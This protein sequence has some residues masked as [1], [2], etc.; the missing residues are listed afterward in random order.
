MLFLIIIAGRNPSKFIGVTLICTI[1]W[2]HIVSGYR[3]T[4]IYL[5]IPWQMDSIW[6]TDHLFLRKTVAENSLILLP[7]YI[8]L[9]YHLSPSTSQVSTWAGRYLEFCLLPLKLNPHGP[10]YFILMGSEAFKNGI[11]TFWAVSKR[12]DFLLNGI[13]PTNPVW[14]LINTSDKRRKCCFLREMEWAVYNKHTSCR[15]GALKQGK[16]S[17]TWPGTWPSE[18]KPLCLGVLPRASN[19]QQHQES[20]N[21]VPCFDCWKKFF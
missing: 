3:Y 20:N 19:L 5:A 16:G 21:Q 2:M 4:V 11:Q 15:S 1:Q 7:N 9:I 10:H 8:V 14:N 13:N 6:F 17:R 12:D 18:P